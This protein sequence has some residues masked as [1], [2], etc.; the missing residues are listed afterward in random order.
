MAFKD[1][2][3]VVGHAIDAVGSVATGLFN[4]NQAKKN[5]A[6]QE[7]MYNQQV[8]DNR[9]TWQMMV[10]YDTPLNQ[11]NRLLEAG[12]N[13]LLMYGSGG[14]SNTVSSP[15]QGGS[16]PH[17]AQG[18]ANFQTNFGQGLLQSMM[19]K[20]QI[21]NM[22]A[23]T[24]QKEANANKMVSETEGQ[25]IQNDISV[26]TKDAQIAKAKKDV[27]LMEQSIEWLATQDHCL[28]N[29]TA[30]NIANLASVMD[31]REK[32]YDLDKSRVENQIWT[33]I[34]SIA[35]GKAQ[36]SL[37]LKQLAVDWYNAVSQRKEVLGKLMV[38]REQA[39]NI[40][41]DTELTEQ[42][43]T[44]KILDAYNTVLKND[45]LENIGTDDLGSVG[46]MILLLSGYASGRIKD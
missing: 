37:G 31:F 41:A 6:F 34:Q 4:S 45:M 46:G 39:S 7:R 29:M 40:A 44:N 11:K 38:F 28:E 30:A 20:S 25:K 32:Y 24:K 23:D 10:D 19:L 9:E 12:L 26:A 8:K 15:A 14:V 43:K 42:E 1:F 3:P 16:A 35:L 22:Q 21:E 36:V 2:I 5:R 13:P 27:D 18:S 33:N 17:G